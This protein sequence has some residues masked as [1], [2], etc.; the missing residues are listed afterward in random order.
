MYI[1]DNIAYA[2]EK[3]QAI[4]VSGVRALDKHR[5]WVRFS[6]GEAKIVDFKPLL[7][8]PAFTPL[9]DEDL[10]KDVYIDYG[11]AVWGN[12]EIDIAPEALYEKGV[13]IEER[14]G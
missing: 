5:L 4:K 7:D 1:I 11:I 2:G 10:F 12:G 13:L 9:E 3:P 6:T 14:V 8:F